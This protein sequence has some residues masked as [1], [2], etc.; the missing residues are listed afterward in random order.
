M[1]LSPVV[2]RIP[3]VA[4]LLAQANY[5]DEKITSGT[6]GMRA[7]VAN[8]LNYQPAWISLLFGVRGI[9]ARMLGLGQ[10]GVPRFR[11]LRPDTLPM[12]PDQ[13]AS[14]FKVRA[15]EDERFWIGEANDRHLS[16]AIAVIVEEDAQGQNRF[17]VLTIVH[18]HNC[19][20]PLYFNAIR[21]FH[22]LVVGS[23]VH[24]GVQ[25]GAQ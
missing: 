1:R 17:H 13:R 9:F 8:M 3:E 4:A 7:F 14:L 19:T 22:H 18:Y 21:P 24:A 20:G 11:T 23:M 10:S 12:T 16:A 6:V 2:T 15:A 5:T 25:G